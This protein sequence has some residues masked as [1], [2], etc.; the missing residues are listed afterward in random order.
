MPKASNDRV[1]S[2][3]HSAD[4]APDFTSAEAV[5]TGQGKPFRDHI[6]ALS[7][8]EQ[9]NFLENA[10][11]LTAARLPTSNPE[12]YADDF[13]M[14]AFEELWEKNR[15]FLWIEPGLVADVALK[16]FLSAQRRGRLLVLDPEASAAAN[17]EIIEPTPPF[18]A[19]L[20]KKQHHNKLSQKMRV[21]LTPKQIEIFET[22]F[23]YE[24]YRGYGID[25]K[26]LA[27]ILKKDAKYATILKKNPKYVSRTIANARN[28]LKRHGL[29]L[30]AIL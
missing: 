21:V 18:V 14:Q 24:A 20:E 2:L 3:V 9:N 28:R 1:V 16:R 10:N 29:S 7:R 23:A 15:T 22:A 12:Q 25:N 30:D 17:G 6:Y 26:E 4:D 11:G 19:Q 5:A 13:T 8:E 27:A